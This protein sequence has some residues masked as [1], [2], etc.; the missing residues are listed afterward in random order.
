[1]FKKK[2][3]ALK[4]AYRVLKPGGRFLCLEFSKVKSEILNKFY[5]TYSKAL[6]KIGQLVIGKSEPY[7]YL[8]DSI[9]KF[10]NQDELY[11]EIAKEKFVNISY[12]NLAYGIAAIHSAWKV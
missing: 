11:K 10:Y 12:R 2:N 8:V 1:M 4:E 3:I 5:K 6:P 9:E 7:Q